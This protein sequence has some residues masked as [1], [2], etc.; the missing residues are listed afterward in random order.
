MDTSPVPHSNA[1]TF[2]NLSDLCYTVVVTSAGPGKQQ[3][4]DTSYLSAISGG[5]ERN[6]SQQHGREMHPGS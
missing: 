2:V 1:R 3:A 6:W 5:Q 4:Q